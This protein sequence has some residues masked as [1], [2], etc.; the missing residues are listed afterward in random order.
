MG[1]TAR[2]EEI[3]SGEGKTYQPS[4]DVV[5]V[6]TVHSDILNL[7]RH[8]TQQCYEKNRWLHKVKDRQ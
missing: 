6:S 7:Q 3:K 5:V 8:K 4:E 2:S 1:N